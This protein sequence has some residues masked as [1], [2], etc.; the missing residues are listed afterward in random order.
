MHLPV[1]EPW[2][3]E[4]EYNYISIKGLASEQPLTSE[5]Y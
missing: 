4:S 2:A 1:L 3:I 5:L